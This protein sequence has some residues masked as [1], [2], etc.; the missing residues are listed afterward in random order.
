MFIQLPSP[1]ELDI[2]KITLFTFPKD[3]KSAFTHFF[4]IPG[5]VGCVKSD[6]DTSTDPVYLPSLSIPITAS[7]NQD[8]FS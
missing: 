7:L 4:K 6:S 2:L 8:F 3:F 1:S 5:E